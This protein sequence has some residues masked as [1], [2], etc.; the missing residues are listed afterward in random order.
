LNH[1]LLKVAAGAQFLITQLFFDNE[2]YFVFVERARRAGINVPIIPGIMPITNAEQVARFTS[3][4]G[5]SIP[6]S[7]LSELEARKDQPEA[8]LDLGVAYATLQCVDLLAAGAPGIHF[9][10]LNKSPAS[11]A[12]VS[13][14]MAARPWERGAGRRYVEA[15]DSISGFSFSPGR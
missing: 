4:C 6:K 8:V 14:L 13:A 2:R 1:L 9:Y 12:V 15:A 5:A 10:T 3:L 11:R 7:L